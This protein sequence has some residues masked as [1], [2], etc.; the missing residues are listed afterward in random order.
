MRKE[1]TN[2]CCHILL[3]LGLAR[4]LLAMLP[5]TGE[6]TRFWDPY[7]N[8]LSLFSA[9]LIFGLSRERAV[10]LVE[11]LT[12]SKIKGV[13]H[14]DAVED[15]HCLQ[16]QAENATKAIVEV[17]SDRSTYQDDPTYEK[18]GLDRPSLK[19]MTL[20]G[21]GRQ[22]YPIIE[23]LAVVKF[24]GY[25]DIRIRIE[26]GMLPEALIKSFADSEA[27]TILRRPQFTNPFAAIIGFA[28]IAVTLFPKIGQSLFSS[29]SREVDPA[30]QNRLAVEFVDPN[31]SLGRSTEPNLLSA[32]GLSPEKMIAYVRSGQ[33][34]RAGPRVD[35]E[36]FQ[37]FPIV[38]LDRLPLGMWEIKVYLSATGAL[39]SKLFLGL[40]SIIEF[41]AILKELDLWMEFSTFANTYRPR[42]HLYNT[43]PN[44]RATTRYD[45]GIITGVCRR[46]DCT[47]VS[48]QSRVFYRKNIYY[49]FDSF[50]EYYM[51]GSS[52]VNAY[53]SPQ[54][55]DK[56][57]PIG[58]IGADNRSGDFA[59]K[60][61]GQNVV[62]LFTSDLD[63]DHPLHYTFDY[64]AQ[65]MHQTLRAI[66]EWN[67]VSPEKKYKIILKPKSPEHIPLLLEEAEAQRLIEK[68]ELDV[69][70]NA[71][72]N[73]DVATTIS[74]ASKVIS[75]GF[76]T[77]GLDAL[78]QGVPSIF[79]TP[80]SG[81]YNQ[82]FDAKDSPIVA[83]N[84]DKL[85]RFLSGD[86][87]PGPEYCNSLLQSGDESTAKNFSFR[88][89]SLLESSI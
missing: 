77:P 12:G 9:L 37:E 61:A 36:R 67:L 10:K 86:V 84:K 40:I 70:V 75:I 39:L 80:Y 38:F 48:Y 17:Y 18:L 41:L 3:R 15:Y 82:I 72:Q 53:K 6:T 25:S 52:W 55:I 33:I 50:D 20:K 78:A 32:N 49:F 71:H 74:M 5:G 51:W 44:G 22:V 76:T 66:G 46:F 68:F 42:I 73:H 79:F 47:S 87:A 19:S 31:C 83:N 65:F 88:M 13:P 1:P 7:S 26:K 81:I 60:E 62:A 2:N 54:F 56:F 30:L 29:K 35:F 34:K 14:G 63:R 59:D 24:L 28:V 69:S 43:I 89:R 64:S 21:I 23:N 57:V 85:K 27:V 4:T 45:S 58:N 8:N 11:K 16:I